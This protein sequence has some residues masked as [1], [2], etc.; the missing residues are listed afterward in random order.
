M[1]VIDLIKLIFPAKKNAKLKQPKPPGAKG[2]FFSGIVLP[3]YSLVT[4][5]T[6]AGTANISFRT[7]Q[8]ING[9]FSYF[10]NIVQYTQYNQVIAISVSNIYFQHNKFQLPGEIRYF[11]FPTLTYGLG[12]NSLPEDADNIDYSHFRF[13]RNVLREVT[14]DDYVGVGYNLDYHWNI[15]DRT[16]DQ[17]KETGFSKYGYKSNTVSSGICINFIHDTRS[18]ENQPGY[19]SYVNVKFISYLKALGS[20]NNWNSLVIDAR[21]YIPLTHKW[22]TELAIWAYAWLTLNGKPP[23]LDLPSIGWDATSN[24]GRGYATGRYRGENM[25]YLETEFRFDLMRNGLLGGVIFGHLETF[26]EYP[27]KH[28]GTVQPGVGAGLRIKFNKRTKSNICL[29]YSFGTHG[30]N[31]LS[32]NI[33]DVY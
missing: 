21:K 32:T 12:S 26:S 18:N 33:N 14:A 22:Y 9:K 19:G 2:P 13:Y 30:S 4:G 31:G 28:F 3:N 29:D 23:Y 11:K 5:F 1:D 8:D 10:N 7:Q 25:L 15:I 17:G 16:A 24:S 27:Y 6:V 20:D